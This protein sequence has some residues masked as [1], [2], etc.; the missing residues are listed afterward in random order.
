MILSLRCVVLLLALLAPSAAAAEEQ[1]ENDAGPYVPTPTVIVDAMLKLAEVGP[2][3]VVYDLG[4]GD[5][6]LVITSAKRLGARGVGI[7]LQGRLV[8][9]ARK[10]AKNEGVEDRARFVQGDL[11][12]AD[13]R[14]AT[15]VMLYLLPQFVV[16]LVPRLR[17]ELRPGTRIVS[18]DYPLAPWRPDRQ[19][20]LDVEEKE[21]IVGTPWTKLYYYVV[22]ARVGGRWE[23]A[24]PGGAPLRL[25]L[26][27]EPD[28]L[29]GFVRD[30]ATELPLQDLR[31]DGDR[32][33][34]G[35]PRARAPVV[36]EGTVAGR[37]M[38]GEARAG[39]AREAWSA[40]YLGP[41]ERP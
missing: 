1:H 4:S 8:E 34:F 19:A 18:H 16:R 32:I 24:L 6:R 5:G 3:D 10:N 14:E 26:A 37:T 28:R 38:R 2:G 39:E 23:L 13:I 20:E 12:E 21:W 29:S 40:R 7:E 22:P 11:F 27:Q 36:L 35:W 41:L 31:V 9:L 17:A 30:G 25:R 33:R 15:V